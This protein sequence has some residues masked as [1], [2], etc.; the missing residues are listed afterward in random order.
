MSGLRLSTGGV[1]VAGGTIVLLLLAFQT[2][3]RDSPLLLG[4]VI[5]AAATAIVWSAGRHG[6]L[7]PA[8]TAAFAGIGHLVFALGATVGLGF[9]LGSVGP[10]AGGLAL[11]LVGGA[12]AVAEWSEQG[13]LP[14]SVLRRFSMATALMLF[15][16]VTGGLIL[17]GFIR[18]LEWIEPG[19]QPILEAGAE[20]VAVGLGFALVALGFAMGSGRGVGWI[21]VSK[22][23]R[24]AIGWMIGGA[25]VLVGLSMLGA[26]VAAAF[27]LPDPEHA[28]QHR[29][30]ELG[31]GVVVIGMVLTI[32]TVVGEELLFRNGI[33]K[34]LTE[35]VS[36]SIAIGGT[37]VL[38]AVGH[39]PALGTNATGT[40]LVGVGFVFVLSLVIGVAYH[41]TQQLL[42]PVVIHWAYNLVV[43]L[44]I[45]LDV[46]G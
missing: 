10:L 1:L 9:G 22:P 39:L 31:T 6:F 28:V 2:G 29:A 21:D 16:F 4:L 36:P 17:A 8:S 18:G 37:S 34:Y 41:R 13:P 20:Q 25:V 27:G 30:R 26:L 3:V 23:T 33:Q 12:L 45:Y 32:V 19:R 24:V 35:A 43:Y 42:V 40:A 15:G 14:W 7:G 11:G 46:A 38:F 5:V 44:S